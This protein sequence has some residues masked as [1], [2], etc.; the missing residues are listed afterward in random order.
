LIQNKNIKLILN[1]FGGPLVFCILL[2]SINYQLHQ[3][4]GWQSSFH[5]LVNALKSTSVFTVLC[6]ISLMMLN[7]GL[8]AL[9]WKLS[10]K[11]AM[12]V[13]F[14]RSF[15]AVFAGNALALFTPNRTG[16]Y[17]GRML[18]LPKN[19]MIK[20]VPLTIVGSIAQ[21]IVTLVAGSVALL[22]VK[23][24]ILS[25]FGN[26]AMLSFWVKVVQY[27]CAAVVILLTFFYFRV[28]LLNRCLCRFRWF[29]PL[30]R[31]LIVLEGFNATILLSILSL[32]II[33]Y[34][35]FIA[36]YLLLFR[37]FNVGLS[38]WQAFWAVSVVFLVIAVVPAIGILSELGI[39]W[40]T[41]IQLL[42]VYS[43]NITGIFATSLA[44]W[45]INLVIP[46]LL[47]GLVILALKL[48]RKQHEAAD[49]ILEGKPD[50]H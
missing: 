1:Y 31:H 39:R 24:D 15:K 23:N 41:S 46:A 5:Q 9:K 29:L 34:M 10:M 48:F 19:A 11:L 12:H 8:E 35:A 36:Q 6:A 13:S 44:V 21:L 49:I 22:F 45:L 20:S 43:S 37:I 50:R 27:M 40:Q 47:G 33:R 7:W 26:S 25:H 4:A 14:S 32:S 42:Q 18:L 28:R 3:Q 38:W 17:F 16:E 30:H 2:Y